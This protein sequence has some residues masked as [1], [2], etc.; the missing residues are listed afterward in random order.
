[1]T[2]RSAVLPASLG[3]ALLAGCGSAQAPAASH[4][5]LAPVP[6][7]SSSPPAPASSPSFASLEPCA[8]LSPVDRSTA[9][10]TSPGE[11]KTIGASRACD[12]TEPGSFGVT[13]TL[14]GSSGLSGLSVAKGTSRRI[15]VGKRA[16]LQV[17]DKKAADG[18]CAVLLGVGDSASAQ[19]DVSN[20][21]FTGTDLACRRAGTVAGLIEPKLPGSS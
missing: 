6:A 19:V 15:K 11:D 13:I 3:L 8:L 17:A 21:S 2:W 4:V 20:T 10:L 5:E 12:W 16:A 1:M 14:D 18:T 9:G 7:V